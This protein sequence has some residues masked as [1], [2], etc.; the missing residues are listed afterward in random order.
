M[1]R[2][3]PRSTQGVSSAAS[4][5]YKRQLLRRYHL[6]KTMPK[7]IKTFLPGAKETVNLAVHDCLAQTIDLLT[8]QCMAK[9]DYMFWNDDPEAAPPEEW[10]TLGDLNTGRAMRETHKR[11]VVQN[12]KVDG[13]TKVPLGFIFYVDACQVVLNQ[14]LNIETLKL[15]LSVFSR[16]TREKEH[17]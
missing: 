6:D 13:R 4:D 12:L 2:R 9:E 16:E 3:P 15:T 1:I 7:E 14:N 10:N 8:D 11:M 5:V 17:A